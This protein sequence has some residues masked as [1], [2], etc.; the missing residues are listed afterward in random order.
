MWN[1]YRNIC[2][3]SKYREILVSL[4]TDIILCCCIILVL[5]VDRIHVPLFKFFCMQFFFCMRVHN[6]FLVKLF[7]LMYLSLL[8]QFAY[9][10]FKEQRASD[11]AFHFF[12]K[13]NNIYVFTVLFTCLQ[14]SVPNFPIVSGILCITLVGLPLS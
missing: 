8:I 5:T 3:T 7:S 12:L 4:I 6:F 9:F 11:A 14:N 10:L 13:L 1:V 2:T